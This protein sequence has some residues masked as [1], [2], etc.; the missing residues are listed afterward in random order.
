MKR[1]YQ[2]LDI[3]IGAFFR[4]TLEHASACGCAVGNMVQYHTGKDFDISANH[5]WYGVI[6]GRYPN[7][8]GA[9][10][11]AHLPY[12][13]FEVSKIERSF[14]RITRDGT[15]FLEC[16]SKDKDGFIGLCD[17]AETLYQLE[18]WKEEESKVNIIQMCLTK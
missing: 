13:V 12:K 17:V 7:P 11:L 6:S 1:Y 8:D 5:N 9:M 14:E 16:K 3:L 10:Q 2:S 15:S 18:D 4:G